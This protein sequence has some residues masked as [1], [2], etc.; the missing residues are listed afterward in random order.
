MS[1]APPQGV[2]PEASH[3]AAT[4][5]ARARAVAGVGPATVTWTDAVPPLTSQAS[6]VAPLRAA[7]AAAARHGA[8]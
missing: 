1:P 6:S 3:G 2:G 8:D 5:P 7:M 4:G